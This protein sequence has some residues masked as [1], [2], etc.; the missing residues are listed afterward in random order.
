MMYYL[1][2]FLL[3]CVQSNDGAEFE[4]LEESFYSKCRGHADNPA[5]HGYCLYSKSARLP[6]IERAS[7]YCEGLGEWNAECR[8]NWVSSRI[9]PGTG[10]DTVQ[11]L[12]MCG[13]HDDCKFKVIDARPDEDLLVQLSL[14]VKHVSRYRYD[15]EMHAVQ[16]WWK[17]EPSESEL[18]RMLALRR[19]PSADLPKYLSFI[20]Q[21][22]GVGNCDGNSKIAKECR[23]NLSLLKTSKLKCPI[24]NQFRHPQK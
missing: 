9:K 22:D 16:R 24:R 2:G 8:Y 14:C 11:L 3:A 7:D 10:F 17:Q 23:R 12:E 18:N 19:V 1:L 15:C 20:V 21:C 13:S 6:T 5:E 4:T